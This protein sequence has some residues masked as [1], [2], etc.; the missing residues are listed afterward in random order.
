MGVKFTFKVSP[1]AMKQ[2]NSKIEQAMKKTGLVGRA[3]V[4]ERLSKTGLTDEQLERLDHPYARRHGSIKSINSNPT[5]YIGRRTGSILSSLRGKYTKQGS[6][7]YLGQHGYVINFPSLPEHGKFIFKGTKV[8]LPR[9][10]LMVIPS[11]E[12]ELVKVFETAV[13]L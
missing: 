10:P 6:N 11:K 3:F 5:E 4:L 9:N 12:K 8:M 2:V 1:T 7:Q 13:R